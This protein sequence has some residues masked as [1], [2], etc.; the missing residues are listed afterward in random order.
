[1]TARY[2]S[3]IP[4]LL[5]TA[6]KLYT[7]WKELSV[8][9][10]LEQASNEF[11]LTASDAGK[12]ELAQHPIRLGTRCRVVIAGQPVIN[13]WIEESEPSYDASAHDIKFSGRDITCDA[14]DSSAQI[15]NQELHNVTLQEAAT[16]LMQP[17]GVTVDCPEPGAKFEKFVVNDGETGFQAIESHARQRGL[18]VYTLGDGILHIRKP[19]PLE[20][21]VTLREGV[22][23]LKASA[24]RS[25]KE[26][27][28]KYQVKSQSKGKNRQA[29]EITD[30]S[31]RSTRVMIVRAE[32]AN[33]ESVSN[34][35]R[36]RWEMRVR[37][38]KSERASITVQGWFYKWGKLWL[39]NMLVTLDSPKLGINGELLIASVNLNADESGGTTST[40][41][42]VHPDAYAA[43]PVSD[44]KES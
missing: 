39:P 5:E 11:S 7:G 38:A 42:L 6:G 21:G 33:N 40:L 22:N 13:G 20:T 41:D 35:E 4:I 44:D 43:E 16:Q 28:G 34:L 26:R 19:N 12:E 3:S 17:Y 36:A 15:P 18:I 25:H 29:A 8:T 14:I 23:I 1:M 10:S 32:K 2:N 30:S 24:K 9:L 27:F 31:I 37:K